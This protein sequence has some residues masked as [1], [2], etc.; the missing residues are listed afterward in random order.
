MFDIFYD[1]NRRKIGRTGFIGDG[2][3][4]GRKTINIK[5]FGGTPLVCVPSVPWTCPICPGMCPV[6]PADILPLEF[7]FP[8]KSAQRPGCPWE[9][10]NLS[11][12]RFRGIPTT[13]FLHVIFLYRFFSPYLGATHSRITFVV[14]VVSLKKSGH[15]PHLSCSKQSLYCPTCVSLS[16]IP[17]PVRVS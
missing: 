8:H 16:F 10:P 17:A 13:N 3:G 15:L 2:L 11:L 9:V 7:E 6:C 5:N 12:G 14:S 4:G 1:L